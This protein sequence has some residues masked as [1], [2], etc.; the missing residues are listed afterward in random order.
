MSEMTK[1]NIMCRL[2]AHGPPAQRVWIGPV[3]VPGIISSEVELTPLHAAFVLKFMVPRSRYGESLVDGAIGELP[4]PPATDETLEKMCRAHDA[5]DSA[6]MGEP[7]IWAIFDRGDF[8][9]TPAHWEEY[10]QER[11][12]AMREALKAVGLA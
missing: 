1:I 5:E 11:F 2:G 6:Q 8:D 9:G 4:G 10:R 7:S 3:E 12:A